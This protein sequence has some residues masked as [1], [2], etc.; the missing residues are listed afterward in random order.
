M[1]CTTAHAQTNSLVIYM[2]SLNIHQALTSFKLH[3]LNFKFKRG[4]I[5]K[6]L[7]F[8]VGKCIF[9]V[10]KILPGFVNHTGF[11][12]QVKRPQLLKVNYASMTS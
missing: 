2:K 5:N 9:S 7:M 6:P 4:G 10:E 11:M 12:N 1:N 3:D 8:W